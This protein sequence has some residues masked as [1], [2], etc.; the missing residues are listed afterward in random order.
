MRSRTFGTLNIDLFY[1][2]NIPCCY[3]RMSLLVYCHRQTSELLPVQPVGVVHGSGATLQSPSTVSAVLKLSGSL[4]TG[5]S[6]TP[7]VMIWSS[8]VIIY[9]DDVYP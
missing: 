2:F 7:L 9:T 6:I 8:C 1:D 3:N 4:L 5:S